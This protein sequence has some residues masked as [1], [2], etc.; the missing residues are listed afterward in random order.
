M[1]SSR[2]IYTFF[3]IFALYSS[4]TFAQSW[5]TVPAADLRIHYVGHLQ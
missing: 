3:C 1:H 4:L 2:S 5:E